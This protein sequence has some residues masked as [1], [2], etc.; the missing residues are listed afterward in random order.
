MSTSITPEGQ[1]SQSDPSRF[2]H[3]VRKSDILKSNIYD[4]YVTAL[5]G[6][7]GQFSSMSGNSTGGGSEVCPEC[8]L[9][10]SALAAKKS[11]RVVA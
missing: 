4:E 8:A 2:L 6:L 11:E 7:C 3:Y 10:Y 9:F 1:N 5:C